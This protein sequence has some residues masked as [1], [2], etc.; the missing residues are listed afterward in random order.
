MNNFV[1]LHT[2]SHYSLCD[3]SLTVKD[4]VKQASN[5]GMPA[6][7]LTDHGNLFGAIE[8]YNEA[9]KH[10][11]KPII[12]CEMYISRGHH[13]E[14]VHDKGKKNYYHLIVLAKDI[15][16]Y[17]NLVKL[18][19]MSYTDG[20]YYKPRIDKRTLKEYSKGL[21]ALSACLGGEISHQILIGDQQ[22]AENVINEYQDIFGKDSF[23]LELQNHGIQK[24]HQVNEALILLSKKHKAPLVA[25]NDVHY[26]NQSDSEAHD[27]LLCIGTQKKVT[28]EKRKRYEGD[29]FYL[30]SSDE[31]HEIFKDIPEAIENTNIIA[32]MCDL[33]FNFKP[34]IPK[35]DLPAEYNSETYLSFLCEEGLK[36]K[37]S[38]ITVEIK[39]RL[40]YELD[41]ICKMGFADYFLIVWDFIQY[42][43]SNNIA[44]GP[45]RGSAAGSLVAYTLGVTNLDP[46][47]YHL[48]FERFLN[49]ERI[50]MP[51]IDTDFQDDK[52]DQVINYVINKYGKEKVAGIITFGALKARAVIR[53][54]GRVLDIPLRE[55]DHLAKLIPS[56]PG[57]SIQ[58]AY[59]EI[60][61]LK[62]LIESKQ[63]YQKLFDLAQKL[64]GINRHAG[65]HAAGIV[66]G[67]DNLSNI[68]PLYC[69]SKT[70][71][72][73]TQ[74]EGHYLEECG[75]LKMDFLG[76]KNLS[77][78]QRCLELIK[79]NKNEVVIIEKIPLDNKKVYALFQKGESLG[80][81]QLESSGMQELMKNLK[82]TS[83]EDI[84]ALIALYRPG[85]LN[86]GMAEE[87]IQRKKHPKKI[88][89]DHPLLERILKETY[90]VIVY[91]EQVMEIARSIG[92]FSMS[93]ADELRK[94]M[95]KK[96]V[97]KMDSFKEDFV[98]GALKQ[99]IDKR[100]AE[101]LYDQMA[102]FAEYGFNK[103][104]S[105]AYSLI[106]YQTAYLKANYPIEY[107]TALLS[108]EK[109][110]TDKIV[111]YISESKNMDIKI[112]PPCV[113]NSNIDFTIENNHIRFGLSAIKNVGSTAVQS[114]IESRTRESKFKSLFNLCENVD[115]RVVNKK[116]L[117]CL[118]KSGACDSLGY[119]RATHGSIIDNVLEYAQSVKNE[120]DRGQ[121]SLFGEGENSS[122]KT[123]FEVKQVNEWDEK[124]ILTCEKEVL[125]FY[126]SGHPLEKH[127]EKIKKLNLS[128][129]SNLKDLK[130]NSKIEICGLVQDIQFKV[131]K[132]GA[133]WGMIV[134]E[135]LKGSCEIMFFNDCFQQSKPILEID[136][137]LYIKGKLNS[138]EPRIRIIAEEAIPFE[139]VNENKIK[140]NLKINTPT[141]KNSKPLNESENNE[142]INFAES[143]PINII[144]QI[145][146]IQIKESYFNNNKLDEIEKLKLFLMKNHGNSPIYLHFHQDN[147]PNHLVTVKAGNEFNVNASEELRDSVLGFTCVEKV[148]FNQVK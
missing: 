111:D 122:L 2:H 144:D 74:Y 17:Y 140:S 125:G 148:W 128:F 146:N 37:Y 137:I 19:S 65:S 71:S 52:R 9:I 142:N 31:M 89:F 106:T 114:L 14:K 24:Q 39:E 67:H 121:F 15:D 96:L 70:S 115:L 117:E 100:L 56:G 23:F 134:L 26:L 136:A 12:G 84:I 6:I 130:I 135:G 94:A 48:L 83:F 139:K 133:E 87:F 85:P 72:L 36:L 62:D 28:D 3:A 61:E 54:V 93:K 16:G 30:K 92:G 120:K 118:I 25:T 76:L 44:V 58:K 131:S 145:V 50:S 64:E 40:N 108:C 112:L 68:V 78:I 143:K 82:P 109:D 102:K 57:A 49:P 101:N 80:V 45:G 4:L 46:L 69:D 60:K 7:A 43:K 86:S 59:N 123:N 29:Q 34:S 20:F 79:S 5:F 75:L 99:N 127:R 1:H 104:H 126:L 113:N 42:A 129:I 95:S 90:G 116:T 51:D 147:N 38:E 97:A 124:K 13:N 55:I 73:L 63:T 81:F 47:K 132:K 10:K 53:D 41:I 98:N 11:I 105:A 66:I 35:I 88:K 107:M 18:T 8:F 110:N 33:K 91:Q 103:S 141:S 32:Q 138:T 77:V 21:I 22:K 27:I 119:N